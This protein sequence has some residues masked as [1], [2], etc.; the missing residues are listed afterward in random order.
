MKKAVYS[1]N[2][3]RLLAL[4]YNPKFTDKIKIL[5]QFFAEVGHPIDFNKTNNQSTQL[6][7]A[8]EL[9]NKKLNKQLKMNK[10]KENWLLFRDKLKEIMTEFGLDTKNKNAILLIEQYFFTNEIIDPT[11]HWQIGLNEYPNK[12]KT[13]NNKLIVVL[14]PSIQVSDL[15]KVLQQ[16]K[17]EYPEYFRKKKSRKKEK[18][19]FERDCKI[20]I[21]HL[22]ALKIKKSSRAANDIIWN[23]DPKY[24]KFN[25][26]FNKILNGETVTRDSFTSTKDRMSK[27]LKGLKLY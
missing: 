20:Y 14:E 7:W 26:E 17:N 13:L 18:D 6:S 9:R 2:Y 21:L 23:N 22:K 19:E 10:H 3:Y 11:P 5:R 24:P 16:A 4:T 8:S 1:D 25:D 15:E 12:S 27:L